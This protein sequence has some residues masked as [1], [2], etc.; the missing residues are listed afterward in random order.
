MEHEQAAELVAAL[1]ERLRHEVARESDAELLANLIDDRV[2]ASLHVAQIAESLNG[3]RGLLDAAATGEMA[4]FALCAAAAL[5]TSLCTI[6][7]VRSAPA[8]LAARC[9]VL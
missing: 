5:C 8:C 6:S 7:R 2:E 1:D 9:R 4:V 3:P